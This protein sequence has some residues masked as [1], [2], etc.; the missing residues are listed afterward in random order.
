[1]VMV[2]PLGFVQVPEAEKVWT[3]GVPDTAAVVCVVA[4]GNVMPVDPSVTAI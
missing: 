3:L 4:S 1:M 2:L